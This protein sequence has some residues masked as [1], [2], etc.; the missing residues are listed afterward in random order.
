[1]FVCARGVKFELV[2]FHDGTELQKCQLQP[3]E[4]CDLFHTST[5]VRTKLPKSPFYTRSPLTISP[6]LPL[7]HSPRSTILLAKCKISRY[8]QHCPQR[9]NLGANGPK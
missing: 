7:S 5:R 1:M 3:T 4:C 2:V 6:S 9:Y 8:H